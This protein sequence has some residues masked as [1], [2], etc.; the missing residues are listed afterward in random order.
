M[1][2]SMFKS[3]LNKSVIDAKKETIAIAVEDETVIITRKDVED[4]LTELDEIKDNDDNCSGTKDVTD[5]IE[6]LSISDYHPE[7]LNDSA[8]VDNFDD[9]KSEVSSIGEN[10]L[11]VTTVEDPDIKKTL[12]QI[13][14]LQ[15][16]F[17]WKIKSKR[18]KDLILY[19]RNKYGEYNLNIT[20]TEFTLERFIGNIIIG[21]ELF[22]NGETELAQMKILEIGTWLED[23]DKGVD[24]FYLSIKSGL[25]HVMKATFIHM[26]FA[27]NLTGECKWLLDDIESF[28]NMDSK[29]RASVHAI[30]AAVLI[31]YGG[32]P[33]YL[34]KACDVAKKACDLD[35]KTSHWFYIH[36]LALTAQ[37]KFL[38]SHTSSPTENEMNTIHQA[39]ILS[40]GKNALFN[41]HNMVLYRD[42]TV[43][44]F[45]NYKNKNDKSLLKKNL[46]K[47]K[48]IVHMIKTIIDMDPKDPHL[49]VKCARTLMTLPIMVR[50]F[51][52]GK[53]YLTK[54]FE[55]APNDA[56]VLQAIENTVQAYKDVSK[57]KQQPAKNK[58]SELGTDI[59][60]IV[61]KLRN[62]EDPLCSYTILFKKNLRSGVEQFIKLIEQSEIVSKDVITKHVSAFGSKTFSLP[63]LIC[64]EIRLITNLSGTSSDMLYYFKMLTKII[65]TYNETVD[66]VKPKKN[67]KAKHLQNTGPKIFT[68]TVKL[69]KA[70]KTINTNS[71]NNKNAPE[72]AQNKKPQ[73]KAND[74]N[75][76]KVKM[77]KV[78]NSSNGEG[79]NISNKSKNSP[80]DSHLEIPPRIQHYTQQLYQNILANTQIINA[81]ESISELIYATI[82]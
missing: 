73:P 17:T 11:A 62:G 45:H 41:Y 52:L 69:N 23:L 32:N 61:K 79:V 59:G 21:Y 58:T 31:E 82:T 57:R 24:E 49:V 19:I 40:N 44:Y 72:K 80:M 75:K 26:L 74:V 37:R 22:H 15:C 67:R 20:S 30:R 38:L 68:Q 29:S 76:M 81:I 53:Q 64:N 78:L 14:S 5:A 8:S 6:S 48:K 71:K 60:L 39:I 50:D 42:T 16:L 25:Q 28:V 33:I 4:M 36:S 63:E 34:K 18:K 3:L 56:T 77:E 9:T 10:Q 2:A 43:G 55:M 70:A 54:A 1:F 46:H 51:N 12:N 47:N 27:T 7:Y 66:K 35:P 65:E 13:N